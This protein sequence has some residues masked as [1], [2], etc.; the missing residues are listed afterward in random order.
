[1]M[2]IL[3]LVFFYVVWQQRAYVDLKLWL[4]KTKHKKTRSFMNTPRLNAICFTFSS[5]L[6]CAQV[7]S[8]LPN[9]PDQGPGWRRGEGPW[10]RGWRPTEPGWLF[11]VR[12]GNQ[13][14]GGG[15][16]CPG[17]GGTT[18]A[19]GWWWG[20]NG[21]W[22]EPAQRPQHCSQKLITEC[23]EQRT[24]TKRMGETIVVTGKGD[25][26]ISY[27]E[28]SPVVAVLVQRAFWDLRPLS[29]H[30]SWLKADLT[31]GPSSCIFICSRPRSLHP[32][33]NPSHY[34]FPSHP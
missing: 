4:K 20:D 16:A 11:L 12:W 34:L 1:M 31:T 15:T 22:T 30:S 8:G 18:R 14:T 13:P 5:C 33:T 3:S 17:R 27:T 24:F 9:L 7:P 10:Q 2:E 26:I 6:L 29:P 23:K 32:P 28:F 21:A 25:Y 19:Q